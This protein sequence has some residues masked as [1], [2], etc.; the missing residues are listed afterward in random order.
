MQASRWRDRREPESR[1]HDS[2]PRPPVVDG[3]VD[4]RPL[5][6][7]GFGLVFR[8]WQVG[9]DREVALKVDSRV[10]TEER[11]RRRFLREAGAAGRLS[12]HGHIVP[13]YDAGVA[14]DGRPYLVMELCRGGS[15]ADRVRRDGPMPADEVRHI[16][17]GIAD[18]LAAAHAIG[19]LHR[20][21]KPGNIL[22]DQYG[23]AKLAD[24]GLA[25]ALD[26]SGDSSVSRETLTPA[27][28]PPEAFAFARPSAP[29]DVYGLA[30]TLYTLL[31]GYPPRIL[32]WPPA[33]LAELT[34][35]LRS[36]VAPVP[37]VHPDLLAV[38]DAALHPEPERRTQTAAALRDA[39]AAVPATAGAPADTRGRPPGAATTTGPTDRLAAAPTGLTDRLAATTTGPTARVDVTARADQPPHAARSGRRRSGGSR[40]RVIAMV[41]APVLVIAA[42]VGVM[43]LHRASGTGGSPPAGSATVTQTPSPTPS[44]AAGL[45][46][47]LVSCGRSTGGAL[48][49][50]IP[51]CW[52]DL[53]DNGGRRAETATTS[54]GTSHRWE[55]YAAGRLPADAVD[56]TTTERNARPEVTRVCTAARERDRTRPG[57]DTTAWARDVQPMAIPGYGEF[58]FCVAADHTGHPPA[59]PVFI[60]GP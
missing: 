26:A 8:A 29:G 23:V 14:D 57:A 15:L 5:G 7:G 39:L 36:P 52:G 4:I 13:V 41:V 59:A 47:A 58:F 43:L 55:A 25:A 10:L 31:A 51:L 46:A 27:F 32:S 1:K 21:V 45:P 18:A 56:V 2:S 42:A 34:A 49:P 48:C 60:T 6:R 22:T 53:V 20:D 40:G 54:C 28:A 50:T 33:S 12:S 17:L 37:G 3:L 9:L 24:F 19:I 35:S 38:L 16:G 30:A 44:A 11:D